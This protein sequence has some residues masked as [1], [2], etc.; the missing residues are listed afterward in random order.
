V[1][2]AFGRSIDPGENPSPPEIPAVDSVGGGIEGDK[3]FA[4]AVQSEISERLAEGAERLLQGAM[5]FPRAGV[6]DGQPIGRIS[7]GE[8]ESAIG[9][10]LQSSRAGDAPAN[11]A[12]TSD[13]ARRQPF[14]VQVAMDDRRSGGAGRIGQHEQRQLNPAATCGHGGW[15]R[16]GGYFP[17]RFAR[18]ISADFASWVSRAPGAPEA[19]FSSS[20]FDSFAPLYSSTSRAR[21]T[22]SI[23]RDGV[24]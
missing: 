21:S 9:A 20:S 16:C 14:A 2:Q 15:L 17:S 5:A 18:R 8:E 11:A 24:G 19:S 23:W 6:Q 13:D 22:V 1:E 10:E 12:Q 3:V 7:I 4:A